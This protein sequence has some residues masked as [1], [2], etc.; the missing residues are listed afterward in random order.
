MRR[1]QLVKNRA[2]LP[3]NLINPTTAIPNF[4]D[5]AGDISDPTGQKNEKTVLYT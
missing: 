2:V 5:P 3:A 1:A 4:S